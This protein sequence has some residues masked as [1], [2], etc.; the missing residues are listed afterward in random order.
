MGETKK[1][2]VAIKGL[3]V[4]EGRFLL[5]RRPQKSIGGLSFWE[6]PGGGLG[7]GEM[8]ENTLEREI[9]EEVNLRVEV[10]K[11][12]WVWGFIKN[13][14][15][16]IIGITY[17]CRAQNTEVRLSA[18][19]EEFNWF[20]AAEI[21]EIDLLPELKADMEKWDWSDIL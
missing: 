11:P 8:P 3:I 16:Q 10:I 21:A 4:H 12:I 20:T 18:E 7:F 15:T 17:L 6:L 13:E 19:H 14:S 2:H 9:M 5:L 1:F